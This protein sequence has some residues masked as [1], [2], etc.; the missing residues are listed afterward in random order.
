[1]KLKE[2][3]Q[4]LQGSQKFTLQSRDDTNNIVNLDEVFIYEIQYLPAGLL[5]REI[6]RIELDENIIFLDK[7]KNEEEGIKKY[8]E[9]DTMDSV[10][11]YE[12]KFLKLHYEDNNL[13]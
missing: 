1:M 13:I 7:N 5:R 10:E 6:L 9:I 2:L 4:I 3:S 8:V 12:E 11:D